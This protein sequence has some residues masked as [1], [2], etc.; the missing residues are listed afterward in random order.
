MIEMR[1]AAGD[2]LN[3][4]LAF[5]KFREHR[6]VGLSGRLNREGRITLPGK[7]DGTLWILRDTAVQAESDSA[8]DED[9]I[10]ALLLTTP[11]A[12]LYHC[13]REGYDLRRAD[14]LLSRK[15]L[16]SGPAC[17]IG[18]AFAADA[19]EALIG[20][21]PRYRVEYD[22][23][24]LR[25]RVPA[26][27]LTESGDRPVRTGNHPSKFKVLRAGPE[28]LEA[29]FPLQAGYEKEE[30]LLP[31][32]PFIQE[33]CRSMLKVTLS[34]QRV[35]AAWTET[36]PVAKAGTN[37]RGLAW[38]QIGGVYTV[39]DFRNKGYGR[40]VF[41]EL[42]EDRLHDG[43]KLAL[44]VKVSN[45]SAKKLYES[46]GFSTQEGFRITYW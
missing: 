13:V 29:L 5:L 10:A 36:G 23:M 42:C 19:V 22:L 18:S 9:N 45:N 35:F 38:D 44:F 15:L 21:E 39:P 46:E 32:E 20:R 3:A 7:G 4:C 2:D 27:P 28:H 31:G 6:C 1:Q 8:P 25:G 14:K 12:M 37:A 17:I 26:L 40:A 33:R 30:V 24:T 11:S 16:G 34:G 41:T 43:R